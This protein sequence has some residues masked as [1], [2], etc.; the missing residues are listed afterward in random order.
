MRR[1]VLGAP[2]PPDAL[3]QAYFRERLDV[4]HIEVEITREMLD[5]STARIES[6]QFVY[7][8]ERPSSG[9]HF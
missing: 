8:Y 3:A 5:A 6:Q 7:P 1:A 2:L 9:D 4:D